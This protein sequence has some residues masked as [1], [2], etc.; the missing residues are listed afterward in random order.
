MIIVVVKREGKMK[1]LIFAV[2]NRHDITEIT[3]EKLSEAGF[4]GTVIASSSLR[5]TIANG[6]EIPMFFSL[7]HVENSKY[8]GNTTLYIV[9]EEE[10]VDEVLE[11]I[12]ESTK[13]F[14]LS[15]GG[16]FVVPLEKFE[17][18]F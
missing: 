4:N 15:D 5:K 8:E 2:I 12:R 13:H 3:L 7:A 9:T 11:I 10:K 17:G 1:H 6:G 18:S 14:T 16:M